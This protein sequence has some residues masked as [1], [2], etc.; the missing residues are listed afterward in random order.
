MKKRSYSYLYFD[1]TNI[2]EKDWF[3]LMRVFL[4]NAINLTMLAKVKHK[5]LVRINLSLEKLVYYV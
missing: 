5:Q 2:L 4:I 3:L 1:F